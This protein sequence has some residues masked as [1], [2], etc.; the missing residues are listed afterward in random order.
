[1]E[2]E[3]D[4]VCS[5]VAQTEERATPRGGLCARAAVVRIGRMGER[6][7][8]LHVDMDAFYAAIEQ[9]DHPEYRGKP[10]IVGGTGRRGVV[11]TASYEARAFGVHSAMPTFK[12]RDRC[13]GGLFVVPR[14]SVYAEVSR[15]IMGVF[16]RY[17]PAVEPLS[18]DEAFL[19]MTGSERLFGSPA[20]MA[21]GVRADIRA[22]TGL[23]AS[24]GVASSKFVAKV[25]SDLDKPDGLTLC[26]FGEERAFLAPLPLKR[27][28]GVGKRGEASL[29]ALGLRT[30]GDVAAYPRAVLE[31]KFGR[32]GAHV[33]QLANA[34]DARPVVTGRARLSHGAERTLATNIVGQSAVRHRLLPLADEV[35]AGLRRA[36]KRAWGVRLKLKYAD[37][38]QVTRDMRLSEPIR[39]AASILRAVDEL[40]ERVETRA[41]IR[42]VGVAAFD[43]VSEEVPL[44][45]ALFGEPTEKREELESALDA[46]RTRFGDQTVVRGSWLETS[47]AKKH[48][49]GPDE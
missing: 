39:D 45:G 21:A 26:P 3:R 1:M 48:D 40:I 2:S 6:R 10:V 16:E 29:T 23:T 46:L 22:E 7:I 30:I 32:F 31:R 38:H 17:S 28:W 37:F 8:I 4:L 5:A 42:L 12:A 25:A 43:L 35:A 24:V 44:Q 27:I 15:Q 20:E 13:P 41:P 36:G 18:L 33:W 14:M 34:M 11:A 49:W 47:S 19:D 9:R